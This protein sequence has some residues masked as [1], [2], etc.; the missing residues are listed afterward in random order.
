MQI[1]SRI[2]WHAPVGRSFSSEN[3]RYPLRHYGHGLAHSQVQDRPARRRHL[4]SYQHNGARTLPSRD[5]EVVYEEAQLRDRKRLSTA[6]STILQGRIAGRSLVQE[7]RIFN[8]TGGYQ[9][10]HGNPRQEPGGFWRALGTERRGHRRLRSGSVLGGPQT[11]WQ[12]GQ[13]QR[14][15]TL[16]RRDE[17]E[18]QQSSCSI[19]Q[20][21]QPSTRD[22]KRTVPR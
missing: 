9:S 19:G 2:L 14:S 3:G 7:T 17:E 11:P 18:S 16:Y 12:V 10:L 4:C 8:G 13:R 22:G 20:K 5:N 1:E 21:R 6:T 15:S